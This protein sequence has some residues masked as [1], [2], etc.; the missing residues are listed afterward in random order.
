MLSFLAR[1]WILIMVT[2]NF[3]EIANAHFYLW[4]FNHIAA[5]SHRFLKLP[6]NLC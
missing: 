5:L 2:F 6:P 3:I 4:S 1:E